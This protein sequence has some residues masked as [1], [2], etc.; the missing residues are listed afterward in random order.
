MIMLRTL[1]RD[2]STYNEVSR[3]VHREICSPTGVLHASSL[4]FS[5]SER[6]SDAGPATSGVRIH[7][8]WHVF[9]AAERN[10]V[11]TVFPRG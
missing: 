9:V 8:T 11:K 2:I 10:P 7:A 1:K 4:K 3:C 5:L 6:G